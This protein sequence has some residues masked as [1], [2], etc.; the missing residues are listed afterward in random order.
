MYNNNNTKFNECQDYIQKNI[1]KITVK[2]TQSE[3]FAESF[4]RVGKYK[5]QQKISDCGTYLEFW[6][7][8]ETL[9]TILH[10]ANFCK[11]RMC[12]LCMSRRSDELFSECRKMF[13]IIRQRYHYRF[14]FCSFTVRNCTADELS[15]VIDD[16]LSAFNRL[17]KR[18][19][20][21]C[22]CGFWRTLEITY[23]SKSNT[24]HPHIHCIFA[25]PPHYFTDPRQ[26]IDAFT[27]SEQWRQVLRYN[28]HPSVDMRAVK[29]LDFKSVA[30]ITKYTVKTFELTVLNSDGT[31]NENKTDEV[32]NTLDNALHAR[33]LV[34]VGGIFKI[35]RAE[36]A[37]ADNEF[38]DAEI[39]ELD[40]II[41]RYCWNS[42]ATS[43]IDL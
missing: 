33:R 36:I 31:I 27:M 38:N 1:D 28:Y 2:K 24:Y 41:S 29:A 9:K 4:G 19:I 3:L 34:G 11:L 20:F 17:T 25:V 37:N 6:T 23:N 5:K 10:K 32:I 21:N 8:K 40:Y 35:V 7:H 13:S 12:P 15:F 30:E 16:I 26:Y 42:G 18:K 43:Y 14:L 22:I 39:N